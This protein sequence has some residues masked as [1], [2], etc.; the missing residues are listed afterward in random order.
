VIEWGIEHNLSPLG[1][2]GGR[3][4]ILQQDVRAG[5]RGRFDVALGLNFS[6]FIFKTR[7]DLLQYFKSVYRSMG[8]EGLFF[9]DAYGGYEA[10]QPMEEPRTVKGGFTYIWDQDV[11]DPINN[12]VVNHIHFKFRDGTALRKAFSYDWRF[13]SLLEIRE[14]LAEAGF[15]RSTTYWEDAD[16]DGE[17][18]G[19]FRPKAAADNEAAFVAYI[20]AE[21]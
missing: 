3:I 18:T 14:L 7:P 2:P 4:K 12:R 16:E 19:V 1:E 10:M 8:P 6:Y 21:P 11:V 5:V 17:G 15:S 20:V 13:W 9:V